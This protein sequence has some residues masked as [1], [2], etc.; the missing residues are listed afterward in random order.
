LFSQLEARQP[1]AFVQDFQAHIEDVYNA[2][3]KAK[4]YFIRCIKSNSTQTPGYFDRELVSQQIKDM[5][6]F[7]TVDL[8]QGGY[9]HHM[10]YKDFVRRYQMIAPGALERLRSRAHEMAEDLLAAFVHILQYE[11]ITE[12][13]WALGHTKIFLTEELRQHLEKLRKQIRTQ[14]AITIQRAFRRYLYSP[15]SLLPPTN[16]HII[17]DDSPPPP[18]PERHRNGGDP[19]ASSLGLR[20]YTIVGGYKIAFPQ[21]RIIRLKFPETGTPIFYPGDEVF[22]IGR[23]QTRGYLIIDHGGNQYH[24]PHYFTELR[25]NSGVPSWIVIQLYS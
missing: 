9:Y 6:L 15:R 21:W 7:E 3:K 22:V 13:M 23:S 19:A 18:V 20:N 8:I 5:T 1:S 14:S 11:S 17:E 12:D 2:L 24:L 4:P 16:N 25:V 10:S